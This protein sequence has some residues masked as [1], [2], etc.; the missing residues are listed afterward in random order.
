MAAG[1][2]VGLCS[3]RRTPSPG[4][5]HTVLH[6]NQHDIGRSYGYGIATISLCTS[7]SPHELLPKHG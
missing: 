2:V 1:V 7:L 5:R 4:K 3:M 6:K